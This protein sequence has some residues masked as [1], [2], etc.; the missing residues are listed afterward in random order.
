MTINTAS[1]MLLQEFVECCLTLSEERMI[2]FLNVNP[3]FFK[4]SEYESDPI[5]FI[6]SISEIFNEFRENNP[7]ITV[8]EKKCIDCKCGDLVKLFKV[9]YENNPLLNST[10]GFMIKLEEGNVSQISEFSSTKSYMSRLNKRLYGGLNEQQV[11]E[12]NEA[13]KTL[14]ELQKC[15]CRLE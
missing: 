4:V 11:I 7:I 3:S 10:F 15:T 12:L 1:Q 9:T 14:P 5:L 2:Y 8:I 13:I 6:D